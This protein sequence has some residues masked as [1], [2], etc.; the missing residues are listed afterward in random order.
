MITAET[1]AYKQISYEKKCLQLLLANTYACCSFNIS[2]HPYAG[3]PVFFNKELYT[4]DFEIDDSKWS[5]YGSPEH[6]AIVINNPN[7]RW[8]WNELS[9][10]S[11]MT[12]DIVDKMSQY[13]WDWNAVFR[14]KPITLEFAQKYSHKCTNYKSIS[15]NK[16]LPLDVIEY[17]NSTYNCIDWDYIS[18]NYNMTIDFV[19]KYHKKKW[20]WKALTTNSS[21]TLS[22]ILKNPSLPWDW[23]ELSSNTYISPMFIVQNANLP[24]NYKKVG[25]NTFDGYRLKL[26]EEFKP[27]LKIHSESR[28]LIVEMTQHP[29]RVLKYL[30]KFQYNIGTEEY[31]FDV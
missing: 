9:V 6:I 30:N 10:L 1:L 22:A 3:I 28:L 31:C 15:L 16:D 5:Y 23:K 7:K 18:Y 27:V 8:N 24:W 21:I 17:M 29:Q 12:I 13:D 14:Y 2:E 19:L 26:Q 25:K 20:N 11:N 4:V